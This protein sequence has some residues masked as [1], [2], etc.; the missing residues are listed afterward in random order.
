MLLNFVAQVRILPQG[1]AHTIITSLCSKLTS[2]AP[3]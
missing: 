3:R 1:Y 2:Q